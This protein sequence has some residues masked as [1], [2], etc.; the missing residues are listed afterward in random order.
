MLMEEIALEEGTEKKR[1]FISE[2]FEAVEKRHM[3][4]CKLNEENNLD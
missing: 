4:R 2:F 1:N 3:I